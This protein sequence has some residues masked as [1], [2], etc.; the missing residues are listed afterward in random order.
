MAVEK[1]TSASNTGQDSISSMVQVKLR[2]NAVLASIFTDVS[3]FAQTGDKSISFPR[4]SNSFQVQKL[5]GATK[6]DD[7]EALFELDKLELSEEAHIQWVIKKF[8]QARA[9]V[10]ILQQAISE[11]TVQHAL[12]L[13]S[14]IYD[15][16]DGSVLTSNGAYDLSGAVSQANIVAMI[17]AANVARIPKQNRAF[18]FSNAEYGVLLGIDGFVDASKSNLDIVK[19]GQIGTLYGIPVFESDAVDAT[20]S[21][22]VHKAAVCYGFGSMPSVEDEKAIAYGTGSRRWVMDQMYGQKALQAGKLVIRLS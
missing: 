22:L 9:K 1:V 12:S 11:A 14:D 3:N 8:D 7:Q 5:S 16:L 13:D 19:N 2:A 15:A 4:W 20:K 17:T 18:I 10:E 6:G 21:Y